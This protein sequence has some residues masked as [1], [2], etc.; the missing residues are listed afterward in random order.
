MVDFMR[1]KPLGQVPMTM[2][3]AKEWLMEFLGQIKDGGHWAIPRA[4]SIYRIDH[5]RQV[6]V[7]IEG[8]GDKATEE[9]LAAIGW[10]VLTGPKESGTVKGE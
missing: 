8:E 6:A 3:Q 9:V 7:R 1:Q 4:N 5:A 2:A 10:T